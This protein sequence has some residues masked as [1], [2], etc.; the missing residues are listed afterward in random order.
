NPLAPIRNAAQIFRA[1]APPI[2]EL[3]WGIDVV[4]RQVHQMTRLVDDLLDVSRITR[5]RVQRRRERVDLATAVESA[6]EASRPLM[7]KW[8]HQLS[9]TLPPEP[10]ILD[11]D[12]TR[13][14][15]IIGNLLNN[16]AK[17][18]NQGGT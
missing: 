18:T 14:A 11:A 2:R 13:L 4:E 17:Y 16:A 5:G 8:G 3:Q 9:V 12:P 7:E 6:I 15:Q 1:K 10:I